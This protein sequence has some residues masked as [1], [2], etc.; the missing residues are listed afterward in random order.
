MDRKPVIVYCTPSLYIPGGVE[1]VLTTK[2]NYLADV[3]GYTVYIILTDGQNKPPYYPLS[4]R[5]RLIRL[6]ID[7]EELWG[8]PLYKKIIVYL[9][10]QRIYKRK[11]RETLFSIKPDITVSLMRREINFITSIKDGSKKVG[12]L[13]VNKKHYRNFKT[14]TNSLFK[15]ILSTLWSKQLIHKLQ[16]LDQ[17]IVLTQKDKEN[18]KKVKRISVIPNP[19]PFYPESFSQCT[20]K[21]VIAVGRFSHEKGFDLLAQAWEIVC[22]KH[23]DWQLQLYG[24]GNKTSLH[25]LISQLNIT[26]SFQINGATPDIIDKYR[27]SS[28][29]VLSSRYEGFGMVVAEAMAC[30]VPPVSFACP[31]GPGDIIR[32]GEDGI[33]VENGNV[34]QLAEKIC[35]LIEN[36]DIRKEMG[37]KACINVRRFEVE[38]IMSQWIKLF[39][40]LLKL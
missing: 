33:L 12:E 20:Q 3:A 35:Y 24:E 14:E 9:Q 23:K 32:D 28:I 37:R 22:R 6:D 18:W 17:F 21:N 27:E 29:F 31:C 26:D 40:E 16:K 19:L 10:K 11:L 2:A 5:I 13:H 1:R 25:E 15:R 34:E 36:E 30:G 38:Q 7:F 4:S 39:E 8:L